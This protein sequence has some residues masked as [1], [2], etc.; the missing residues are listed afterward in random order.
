ME[1][2]FFKKSNK[3]TVFV[4]PL[5]EDMPKIYFTDAVN[6]YIGAE[7]SETEGELG[8]VYVAF[9]KKSIE[10]KYYTAPN[11]NRAIL[12]TNRVKALVE[13]PDYVDVTSVEMFYV[14]SYQIR[15]EYLED[16]WSFL[17]GRYTKISK[18]ARNKIVTYYSDLPKLRKIL[19]PTNY[20]KAEFLEELNVENLEVTEILSKPNWEQ[21]TFKLSNF[22]IIE[23]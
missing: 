21:E 4:L 13:H 18:K 14:Y 1:D 7:F 11:S 10:G 6:C 2:K 17:N 9:T 5:I 15:D 23:E 22:L 19:N 12:N 3:S 16:I 8:L 20:D